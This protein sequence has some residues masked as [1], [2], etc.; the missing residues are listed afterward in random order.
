MRRLMLAAALGLGLGAL[1]GP[2]SAAPAF[3]PEPNLAESAGLLVQEVRNHRGY[4]HGRRYYSSGPRYYG[5]HGR[6]YGR[7]YGGPP[8]H[9]RAYGRRGHYYED[10]RWDRRW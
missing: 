4:H 2:A 10:R 5:R 8:P 3:G 1:S 9:A 7:Y 6:G